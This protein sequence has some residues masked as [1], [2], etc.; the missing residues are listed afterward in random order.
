MLAVVALL[1]CSPG[2]SR[3][4]VPESRDV[5]LGPGAAADGGTPRGQDPGAGYAYVAKRPHAAVGLVGARDLSDEDARRVV[6]RLADDLESCAARVERR[7][8]LAEGAMQLVA[9][10]GPK[11]NAE[12]TDMRLAPGGPVAAN[13]L[14]C[15]VAPMRASTLVGSGSMRDGGLPTVAIEATWG[16]TGARPRDAGSGL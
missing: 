7:G 1:G 10:A 5:R 2:N 15:V 12:V 13:A 9:I 6:D 14:E 11:G 16:P 8:E 4:V 3:D